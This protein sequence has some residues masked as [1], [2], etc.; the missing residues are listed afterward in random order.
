MI[1]C[2]GDFEGVL[3]EHSCVCF[4]VRSCVVVRVEVS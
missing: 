2:V 3:I 1:G 4:C